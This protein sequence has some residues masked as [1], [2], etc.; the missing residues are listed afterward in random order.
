M[1]RIVL[2]IMLLLPAIL[3]YGQDISSRIADLAKVL[4]KEFPKECF[5]GFDRSQLRRVFCS[6][7]E[8]R[9]YHIAQKA[10]PPVPSPRENPDVS[11]SEGSKRASRF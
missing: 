4:W 9:P 3:G 7:Q 10:H 5:A 1:K 11:Y 8:Y 6:L 2:V